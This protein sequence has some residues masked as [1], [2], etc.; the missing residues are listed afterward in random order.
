MQRHSSRGVYGAVR[1]LTDA[2]LRESNERYISANF[3]GSESFAI[4]MS[5]KVIKNKVMTPDFN[6]PGV[7]LYQWP[8]GIAA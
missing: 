5:V 2:H 1:T 8:G 7:V 4:L 3:G 6:S